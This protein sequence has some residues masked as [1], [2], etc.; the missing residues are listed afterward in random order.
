[1]NRKQKLI[2]SITGI[3]IVLL[4]LL[5]LTYGYYLTRIEGNT[6]SNSISITT[7]DLTL[8]YDDGSSYINLTNIMPGITT[9]GEGDNPEPKIFT[10]TN[11]GSNDVEYSIGMDEVTNTL[12]R[13][14]DLT[15]SI[16]CVEK[17]IT[18]ADTA[19][20][21]CTNTSSNSGEYPKTN[22]Y[23]FTNQIKQNY[24]QKYVVVISYANPDEDQSID[25]G[26]TIKGRMQIYSVPETI[27]IT[28]TVT[29]ATSG[30]YVQ[31]NSNPKTSVIASDGTYKLIGVEP[32]NHTLSIKNGNTTK[33]TKEIVVKQGTDAGISGNIITFTGS[34]R[35]AKV[36]ITSIQTNLG[37]NITGVKNE[38]ILLKD[39]IIDSA[40]KAALE[41]STTRTAY[42]ETPLTA[43]AVEISSV[44]NY[45]TIGEEGTYVNSMSSVS[46][47][48][49]KTWY[50]YDTYEVDTTTG[51][52]TLSGKQSCTYSSCYSNLV[53]KYL[54]NT[55][56][57]YN[58]NANNHTATTKT[59]LSDI[60]KVVEA[61]SSSLKYVPVFNSPNEA[62]RVLAPTIDDY[63]TS[64]YF[65]GDVE[66][67]YVNFAG[68]CWR[69]VRIAG[70]GSIKLMLEDKNEVCS[71]NID[72]DWRIPNVQGGD[73]FQGNFGYTYYDNLS[74]ITLL[75]SNDN[76]KKTMQFLNKRTNSV[77]VELL[78]AEPDL[79]GFRYIMKYLDGETNY[80]TSMAMFFKNFQN[81]LN[82]NELSKL[83]FGGWC[84]G[85]NAYL[86]LG[87][88]ATTTTP[89]TKDERIN[90]YISGQQYFYDSYSRLIINDGGIQSTLK[91][92]GTIMNYFE[93][94]E[95]NIMPMYV[96]GITADEVMFA[97]GTISKENENYYLLNN[98]YKSQLINFLTMSPA[99]FI[100][101][102]DMVFKLSTSGS[103]SYGDIVSNSYIR[104]M[105]SLKTGTKIIQGDG[106]QSNPY[107]IN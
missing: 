77:K 49:S 62:E 2:I 17:L 75:S 7:A 45:K 93:D 96:G 71:E 70:D 90:N 40:Q 6:N 31:I 18:A 38:N 30:D 80:N 1:M 29:G 78:I 32:G 13:T 39:A 76:T 102:Y 94:A 16:T 87:V 67:N 27:D 15:Y 50:Y 41:N 22:S 99:Y 43:P 19:Y 8:K 63:E 57:S 106:T 55:G 86:K 25:M 44:T 68:M 47:Y 107:I 101:P 10:V 36:N 97:G 66:D 81:T 61:T 9:D 46:S 14:Q 88:D 95:G 103:L 28:G 100:N 35:V 56:A 104:P 74:N 26:S 84:L 105:I 89:L 52:F 83:K 4:A 98:F 59:N 24:V 58:S 53:G 60:Y 51:K 3:T 20:T 85:D 34:E 5:G 64:Y 72:G 33:G 65:R 48:A 92:N 79:L 91:C 42:S 12:T 37:V 73:L 11:D 23:L 21:A 69:I 54:Y 82:E